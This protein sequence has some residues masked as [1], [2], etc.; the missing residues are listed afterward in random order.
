[1]K[2]HG[3]IRPDDPLWQ[4]S[5]PRE[6]ELIIACFCVKVPAM[7]EHVFQTLEFVSSDFENCDAQ[8]V[9]SCICRLIS[10][11]E[12]IEMESLKREIAAVGLG[13]DLAEQVMSRMLKLDFVDAPRRQRLA[14]LD[15]SIRYLLHRRSAQED[16]AAKADF[17]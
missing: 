3:D 7:A 11:N 13:F 14:L 12:P 2:G 5:D 15:R 8:V 1:M 16:A 17:D 4:P 9:A 10:R 6:A